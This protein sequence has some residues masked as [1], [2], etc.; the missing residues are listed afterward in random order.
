MTRRKGEITGL[1]NERDFPHLVELALPRGGFRTDTAEFD[2][3]HR[4]H[5]LPIRRGR[6]RQESEQFYIRFCF[7]DVAIADAFRDRFGGERM[8]Y[9]H[10]RA[11]RRQL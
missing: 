11:R 1:M 8:M 4:E 2:A 10:E 6:G 3:F 7:P 5:G 9:A